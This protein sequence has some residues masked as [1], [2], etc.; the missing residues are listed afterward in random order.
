MYIVEVWVNQHPEARFIVQTVEERDELCVKLSSQ[1]DLQPDE[2]VEY[3][4][5]NWTNKYM[6]VPLIELTADGVDEYRLG[7]EVDVTHLH[8]QLS[9]P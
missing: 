8:Y 2:H 1:L 7:E 3:S 5:S 4:W 6:D 9:G